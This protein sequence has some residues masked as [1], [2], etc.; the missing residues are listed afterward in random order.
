MDIVRLEENG[1]ESF[2]EELWVDAQR[3]LAAGKRYTLKDEIREDGIAFNRSHVSD[4]ERVV[5]LANREEQPVGYV[6]A[7]IQTPPPMIEQI[8]ECH[9]IELFVRESVRQEGVGTELLSKIND[10]ASDR[11]CEY[12]KLMVSSDNRA[13]INLY[14]S[15]DYSIGRHSMSKAISTD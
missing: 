13:A 5:F 3:E 6:S 11:G 9:I 12:L 10:W 4:D 2:V 7:E 14:E 1:I 15:E 8:R